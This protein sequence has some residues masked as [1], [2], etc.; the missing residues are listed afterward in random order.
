MTNSQYNAVENVGFLRCG[1]RRRRRHS[2]AT[3]ER[4]SFAAESR[5]RRS[6]GS[7]GDAADSAAQK[8]RGR[9]KEGER[10]GRGEEEE[11]SAGDPNRFCHSGV[12]FNIKSTD[13]SLSKFLARKKITFTRQVEEM[14]GIRAASI[15]QPS[16]LGTEP[17]NSGC[18]GRQQQSPRRPFSHH[19]QSS[20]LTYRPPPPRWT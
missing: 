5:P 1:G 14:H 10:E 20:R 15:V 4:R 9:R 3:K 11:Y 12:A 2:P 18:V 7:G 17:K 6:G 19:S 8:G 13:L 16:G